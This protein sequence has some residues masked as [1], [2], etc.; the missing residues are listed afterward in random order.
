[1]ARCDGCGRELCLACAIPVRGRTLGTEC[2]AS[3]L[4]PHTA[5]ADV[6]PGEPGRAARTLARASFALAVLATVLPWSRFGAGSEP[7]GAWSRTASWSMLAALAAV[8]GLLISI[9]RR[10][11]PN[12]RPAWDALLAVTGAL[13]AAASVLAL[14]RPPPFT[15]PWLGPW[16]AMLGGLVAAGASAAARRGV[17]EREPTHI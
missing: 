10:P 4:G 1:M 8:A 14:L 3:A 9:G 11:S 13:V 5:L 16:V 12:G 6:A 15:S 7:F 17:R 2:L